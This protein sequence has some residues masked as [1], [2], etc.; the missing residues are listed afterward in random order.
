MNK[1]FIILLFFLSC[2]DSKI[3]YEYIDK[4]DFFIKNFSL[5][6]NSEFI[7]LS[8]G[9]TY[10]KWENKNLD[11]SPIILVHGFSVPSY[12][13]EPTFK[14]LSDKG[15]FVISLDLY[16]RGFSENIND[17]Y[18]DELFANQIIDLLK[19][20]DINSAK[21]VGLSNGGRVI[22]KVA[23]L[24]PELVEKLIYVASSG[25]RSIV[26]EKNKTVSQNEVDDFIELNYPTISKGQLED[27][28]YPEQHIGWD[29]KYDELLKY[30]GFARALISTRKNHYL[31]DNIHLKIQQ[32]DIP[33]YTIWGDSDKVIV[34]K[35][36]E[37]KIDSILPKRKEFFISESGHLPHMENP[38]QF[39][40]ILLSIF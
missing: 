10:Y 23:D 18:T 38:K 1:I 5:N 15:Y 34:F 26:E 29:K 14:M 21:L 3:N 39:N 7:Q 12:I 11:L 40:E 33:V 6:P 28:K 32:S 13:W 24:K 19:K 22:S 31:M 17:D 20:L 36:F 37:N 27:F 2:S 8:K 9:F 35:K 25:F 30:K 16:G 4:D